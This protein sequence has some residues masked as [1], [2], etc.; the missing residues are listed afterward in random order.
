MFLALG[1]RDAVIGRADGLTVPGAL[2]AAQ[3]QPIAVS[4]HPGAQP[5]IAAMALISELRLSADG[6]GH[7]SISITAKDEAA[8]AELERRFGVLKGMVATGAAGGL[9][10]MQKARD[11][12]A[13]ASVERH[14]A[15]IEATLT[16]PEALRQEAIDR[17]IARIA[18]HAGKG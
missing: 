10:A 3:A 11:L 16:V 13:A 15:G 6:Q 4:V 7:V 14:G 12:L 17:V 8:G 9:P 2:P 1:E 18:A 5:R